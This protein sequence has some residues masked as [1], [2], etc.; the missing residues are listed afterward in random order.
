MSCTVKYE[1]RV[2]L[3]K[4]KCSD[5]FWCSADD[6]HDAVVQCKQAK[7]DKPEHK[8]FWIERTTVEKI[9]VS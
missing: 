3:G 8:E 9:E 2:N 7:K 5:I 4:P 6:F 1:V